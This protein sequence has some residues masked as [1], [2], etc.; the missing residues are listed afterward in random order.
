MAVGS[1]MT[2]A[3]LAS[4]E[5]EGVNVWKPEAAEAEALRFGFRIARDE[6][7]APAHA[8]SEEVMGMPLTPLSVLWAAHEH[9]TAAAWVSEE[10]GRITGAILTLPLTPEG[11]NDLLEGRFLPGSPQP[12]QLCAPGDAFP[13][14]Y[15]WLFAGGDGRARRGI[16]RTCLAWRDGAYARVRGYARGASPAGK[17]AL[18][19]LG[20]TPIQSALPDLFFIA[21]RT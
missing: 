19:G 3:R 2:K 1:G 20:F 13:A 17:S 21:E 14:I 11:E 15:F 16:L 18:K 6:D 8:L 5:H 10:D 7:L 4:R 9:T 12:Y